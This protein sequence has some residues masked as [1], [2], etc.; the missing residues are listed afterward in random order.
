MYAQTVLFGYSMYCWNYLILFI[1]FIYFI[2]ILF[3]ILPQQSANDR[4]Q[5]KTKQMKGN[6]I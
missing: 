6:V 2:L 4:L 3:F 5:K 1:I